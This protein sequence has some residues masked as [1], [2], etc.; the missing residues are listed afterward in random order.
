MLLRTLTQFSLPLLIGLIVACIV[1]MVLEGRGVRTT[2]ALTFKGDVKRES[3]WCEIRPGHMHGRG[4]GAHVAIGS[5][6]T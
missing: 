5:Q 3:R 4:G 1:M 2:L 6:A